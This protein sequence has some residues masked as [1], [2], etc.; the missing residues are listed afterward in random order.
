[1]TATGIQILKSSSRVIVYSKC[2]QQS[3][4]VGE[5]LKM[6]KRSAAGI[7]MPE[8]MTTPGASIN[9]AADAEMDRQIRMLYLKHGAGLAE[10]V[11]QVQIQQ[12]DRQARVHRNR[13]GPENRIPPGS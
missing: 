6:T 13:V 9:P 3:K 2:M 11:E 1:L 7:V 8:G 12:R 10:F 4:P 5:P